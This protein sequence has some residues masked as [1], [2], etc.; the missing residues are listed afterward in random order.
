[1]SKHRVFCL[2]AS[3]RGRSLWSP[4]PSMLRLLHQQTPILPV[5]RLLYNRF[6]A[7]S[8]NYELQSKFV[9]HFNSRAKAAADYKLKLPDG[10]KSDT[11]YESWIKSQP[12]PPL[13]AVSL[14]EWSWM[15]V[16]SPPT[17]RLI[18]GSVVSRSLYRFS[19]AFGY[20]LVR[21]S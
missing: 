16:V 4:H 10:M 2:F 12:W 7:K 15:S 21:N 3:T 6:V 14:L 5:V 19:A 9:T 8:R 13:L 18:N 1:M 11:D 17:A 20:P